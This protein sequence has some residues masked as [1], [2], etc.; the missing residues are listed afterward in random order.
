MRDKRNFHFCLRAFALGAGLLMYSCAAM[1]QLGGMGGGGGGGAHVGPNTS[2]GVNEKDELKTFHHAM[3][4]QA[5]SQ[6]A[7]DFRTLVR[8]TEAAEQQLH[9]LIQGPAKAADA[10]AGQRGV[11]SLRQALE[12]ARNQT[13]QFV[14]G[15]SPAQKSGLKETTGKLLKA[16]SDLANQERLLESTAVD[17]KQVA[18]RA[19]LQPVEKAL[20]AFR[21][22][23]D[24]LGEEMGVVQSG[25]GQSLAFNIPAFKTSVDVAGLAVA[26][27]E[28]AV[29]L[30][31]SAE[32]G[33]NVFKVE[34][35]TSLAD[36]QQ[37]MRAVLGAQLNKNERCGE[38]I[39]VQ[40]ATLS[41]SIPSSV[42]VVQV[43]YERWMCNRALGGTPNE[44]T[45]GNARVELTLTPG[46][47]ANGELEIKAMMSRVEANGFVSS[48]LRTGDLGVALKDGVVKSIATA[49]TSLKTAV[50]AVAADSTKTQ[51]A[52]FE[53]TRAGEL[54]VVLGGEM[55]ISEEQTRVLA[56]QIKERAVAGK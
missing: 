27:T 13:K 43:H 22:E 25:E 37:N 33:Q 23:Q 11:A 32:G 40:N 7:A 53:S 49:T 6:Q 45:E 29:I 35:T 9:E 39:A 16:E 3:A 4:V 18:P 42:A 1:A 48:L 20:A 38:R 5:T 2:G 52:R 31:T 55:R 50:P 46:V 10:A 15:F 36:L 34:A 44:M 28:S 41:P 47:G 26:I 51:S 54:N 21:N 14:G 8:N 24:G 56:S 30:R 19:D 17:S 12:A